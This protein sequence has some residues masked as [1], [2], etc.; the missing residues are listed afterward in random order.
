MSA[1]KDLLQEADPFR[2]ESEPSAADRTF[3]RQAILTA[4]AKR[5]LGPAKSWP[6]TS[7]YLSVMLIAIVAF[8]AVS[9]LWSPFISQVQAAV[10][11]EVRL[12]E[13]K[14]RESLAGNRRVLDLR[15][16]DSGEGRS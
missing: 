9:G 16:G 15:R 5:P 11:F 14:T 12:V 13:R 7:V 8:L 6:R 4:A 3:Q 10:R 2:A 1:I